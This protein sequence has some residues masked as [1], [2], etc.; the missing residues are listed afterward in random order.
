MLSALKT[1]WLYGSSFAAMEYTV[2]A[3]KT[4]VFATVAKKRG[5]EFVT[6]ICYHGTSI[7][8]VATQLP[9]HQHLHLI[10]NSEQVLLKKVEPMAT[11]EK[12][13]AKAFPGLS[14]ASFYYELIVSGSYHYIAVCRRDF[15]D[16]LLEQCKEAKLPVRSIRLAFGGVTP[17]LPVLPKDEVVSAR[18]TFVITEGGIQDFTSFEGAGPTFRIDDVEVPHTHLLALAGLFS[19]AVPAVATNFSQ[20]NQ[21]LATAYRE[22]NFFR[23]G[24]PV[25]IGILLLVLLVNFFFYNSY[26]S[27]EQQ[28]GST[29]EVLRNQHAQTSARLKALEVKEQ[30]IE[31][32]LSSGVSKSSYYVN[33]VMA[34]APGTVQLDEFNYQPLEKKIKKEKKVE[35]VTGTIEVR[36]A[37]REGAILSDWVEQLEQMPWIAKVVIVHY[38]KEARDR[39][40]FHLK[41]SI[42]D[43]Q[44]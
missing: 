12:S 40:S 44:N 17:L 41:I 4:A 10:I 28:L 39:H 15:V 16:N 42:D 33:R 8:E 29:V 21:T 3:G 30:R 6:P 43:S 34:S 24:M 5:S 23:K 31:T 19:D 27:E 9:K 13:V 2:Q 22:Q 38:G 11:L 1:Y 25:A 14:L 20:E 18:R 37:N 32:M 35:Y 26:F 36:G 7:H